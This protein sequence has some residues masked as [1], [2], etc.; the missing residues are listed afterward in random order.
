MT[1]ARDPSSIAEIVAEFENEGFSGQFHPCPGG[2]LE[3]LT[4]RE[5]TPASEATLHAVRRTE[6]ASDPDD[7]SA[8]VALESPKCHAKGTVVLTYGPEAQSDDADVLA[9]LPPVD[10]AV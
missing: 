7:M 3:C 6:G 8:I 9:A 1:Y 4:C 2:L 5:I 10:R